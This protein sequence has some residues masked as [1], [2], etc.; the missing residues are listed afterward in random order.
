MSCLAPYVL[1]L[2]WFVF[3]QLYSVDSRAAYDFASTMYK[4]SFV[5]C[6]LVLNCAFATCT[7]IYIEP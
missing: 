1:R 3:V 4:F 5:I 7:D 2:N 6:V